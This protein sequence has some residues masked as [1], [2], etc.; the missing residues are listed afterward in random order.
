MIRMINNN[1]INS[2][3][4]PVEINTIEQ[5]LQG[6][7]PKLSSYLVPQKIGF[8]E[9]LGT[10]D[11]KGTA[12][13]IMIEKTNYLRLESFE[14]DYEFKVGQD[15]Q[16]PELHVYLSQD[17]TLSNKIY[18]DKLQTKLG[19]KNY[20]LPHV[21]LNTYDTVLIFDEIRKEPFVKIKLEDPFYIR[22]IVR[23]LIDKTKI[24]DFPKIES[25]VIYE[26]YG[27]LEGVSTYNAKGIATVDYV[28][29]EGEL[30]IENFEISIGDDLGLY[31]TK[32][33]DVKKSGYWTLDSY[34]FVY[35][36]SGNTDEVLRYAPDGTFKD[37]FY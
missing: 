32:S 34:G 30:K 16:I 36:S 24:I 18:L 1:Q 23:D 5:C 10:H 4:N 29:D 3:F 15:F 33:G 12:K 17:D 6:K 14:I 20:K 7:L 25:Q 28:E 11:A 13:I 21:D 27:F 37:V 22:D 8:L 19:S 2:Y 35:I 26:R 9:G 31:L